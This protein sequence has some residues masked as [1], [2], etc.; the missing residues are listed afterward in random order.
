MVSTMEILPLFQLQKAL[1]MPIA[2]AKEST[3]QAAM[4]EAPSLCVQLHLLIQQVQGVVFMRKIQVSLQYFI[5]NLDNNIN[6]MK[7]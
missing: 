1:A 2:I 7:S 6:K 4:T 3:T 5:H